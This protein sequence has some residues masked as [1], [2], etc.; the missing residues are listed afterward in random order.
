MIAAPLRT[1]RHLPVDV[2]IATAVARNQGL[3]EVTPLRPAEGITHADLAEAS[4]EPSAMRL[5]P[6]RPAAV[7]RDHLIHA[8]A[9]EEPAIER[10]DAGLGEWQVR[11]V[12]VTDGKWVGHERGSAVMSTASQ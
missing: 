2:L 4:R 8:V 10:R 11:T 3:E 7:D 1:P 5:Q 9:I 6:K 12:E